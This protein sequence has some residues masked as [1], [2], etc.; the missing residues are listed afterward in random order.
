MAP[1]TSACSFPA[2]LRVWEL[3]CSSLGLFRRERGV[4]G[5]PKVV[6]GRAKVRRVHERGWCDGTSAPAM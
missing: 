6:L 3:G 2:R 5:E 1:G 4:Q